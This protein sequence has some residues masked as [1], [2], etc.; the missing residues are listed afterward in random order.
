VGQ[1]EAA[2]G[3]ALAI[4]TNLASEN[5]VVAMVSRTVDHFG[6][7]D[8]LVNNAAITFTGDL[9][10]PTKRYDLIMDVNVRA[11][12][13]AIREAVPHL[14][15]AGGGSIVNVSSAAALVPVTQMAVYGMSKIALEHATLDAARELHPDNIAVNCFRIDVSV[16]TEGFMANVPDGD[17]SRWERPE[18]AAEG[19]VWMLR[20]PSSYTGRRESM[21]ELGL[22]EGVMPSR[23]TSAT[24][25]TFRVTE[26]F[27]GLYTTN[28]LGRVV[29]G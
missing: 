25:L 3:E 17:H 14:R 22:R 18:V 19:I 10:M 11:P 29:D 15:A 27:N 12:F 2:G 28:S 13:I 26:M 6:R 16:A 21:F 20:Q 9:Q 24:E 1:I 4:P 8:L 23:S 7:L 5:D